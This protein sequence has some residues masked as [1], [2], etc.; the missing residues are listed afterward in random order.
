MQTLSVAKGESFVARLIS[1]IT[2]ESINED[3]TLNCYKRYFMSSD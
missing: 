3:D 2:T 1:A